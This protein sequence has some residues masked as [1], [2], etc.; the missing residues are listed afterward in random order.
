MTRKRGP[1]FVALGTYKFAVSFIA[2]EVIILDSLIR[3]FQ[4]GLARST[5][6]SRH[7]E[8]NSEILSGQGEIIDILGR[9]LD[10]GFG[11][12]GRGWE[13]VATLEVLLRGG[14][15]TKVEARL[16][17]GGVVWR[18]GLLEEDAGKDP[19]EE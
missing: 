1:I 3:G 14:G 12:G 13:G 5:C 17:L 19:G 18:L 15:G 11:D 16:A 10:C 6:R 2:P 9:E 8:I 7:G 4:N